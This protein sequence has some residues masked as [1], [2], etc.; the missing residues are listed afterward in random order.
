MQFVDAKAFQTIATIL[1]TVE[2]WNSAR[3]LGLAAIW[4]ARHQHTQWTV[5]SVP[6]SLPLLPLSR[7]LPKFAK[8]SSILLHYRCLRLFLVLLTSV[9]T[10][11]LSKALLHTHRFHGYP[12]FASKFLRK[13]RRALSALQ[14]D[15]A[16]IHLGRL[17]LTRFTSRG[18]RSQPC[19]GVFLLTCPASQ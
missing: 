14:A 11:T 18:E 9:R 2:T 12:I 7:L 16:M 5:T 6:G 15:I 4:C 3:L 1:P 13:L 10:L 8:G 19:F 17:Y